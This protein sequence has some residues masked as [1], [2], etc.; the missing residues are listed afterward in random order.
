VGVPV[1]RRGVASTKVHRL[2]AAVGR[3]PRTAA[4]YRHVHVGFFSDV[5]WVI[6]GRSVIRTDIWIIVVGGGGFGMHR[7]SVVRKQHV[8]TTW[9]L[10]HRSFV[11][12]RN[13]GENE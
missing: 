1:H 4:S 5:F 8:R 3:L 11:F 9:T 13:V 2:P 6:L 7:L 12:H 10:A